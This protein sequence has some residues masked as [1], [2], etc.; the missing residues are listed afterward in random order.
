[1]SVNTM[2]KYSQMMRWLTRPQ[3]QVQEPRIMELAES[4]RIRFLEG[5]D[6]ETVKDLYNKGISQENIAS[7]VGTSRMSV[8]RAIK[9]LKDQNLLKER[10]VLEVTK[11]NPKYLKNV[12]KLRDILEKEIKEFNK[13]KVFPKEKYTANL[14]KL[15]KKMNVSNRAIENYI[16]GVKGLDFDVYGAGESAPTQ[17]SIKDQNKFKKYYKTKTLA[18]LTREISGRDVRSK[19]GSSVYNKLERYRDTLHKKGIIDKKDSLFGLQEKP[20]GY[21]GTSGAKFRIYEEQ[22]KRLAAKDPSIS[23]NPKYFK[24]T[25]EFSVRKLDTELLKFL[26]MDTIKGSLDLRFPKYLQPSFEHIQGIT[27][28]DIIGDSEALRRVDL[29]TRRYNFK[30]M[31]AKSNL[32]RDV[33]DYLRTAQAAIKNKEMGIANEAL[34]VVNE[35][36]TKASK[37]FPNLGRKDLPNYSLKNGIVTET[38]LKGL[39]KPQ[40][41]EDSF[42]TFFKSAA[43]T[44]TKSELET[45]KRVQPNAFKVIDMFQKG[46]VNEGYNLIK[47]RMP[48]VKGGAK[49]AVPILA[50]GAA[51]NFLTSPAEAGEAGV[52]D[53]AKSWP[54]E[55]PW[56]TGGAAAGAGY[57]FR[58]PLWKAAKK[59]G[60]GAFGPTGAA[61][62]WKGTGGVDLK[63][64]IDRAGLEA[65]AAFAP[66]LVKGTEYA[67]KGIKSPLARQG[68]QRFLNLGMALPMAMRMARMAS[69]IG[70]VTLAGEGIYQLNKREQEKKAKMSP[71]ELADYEA[72]L[73]K[74]MSLSAA[75]GGLASL[76][77]K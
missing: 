34:G 63:S 28:G 48:S 18:Q 17:L 54:I 71:E 15:A 23:K 6:V 44:T 72:K 51:L 13:S 75:E 61:A 64:G 50:G 40:K 47:A 9:K 41:V 32:Y 55:H 62:L 29:A 12:K 65:E 52:A 22:Q 26:N 66:S 76:K 59:I 4:E 14:S 25:G 58:K 67:T 2:D 11:T 3:S 38:N 27:P 69:P 56:L 45:L 33:K 8:T 49:F 53:K 60:A 68:I 10:D 46:K 35:V 31:G 1:M 74:D 70:W 42:K 30:E 39:I 37:R 73:G 16:G 21:E 24:K 5:G 77:K 7:K 20:L 57:K 19:E 36:Y 43:D